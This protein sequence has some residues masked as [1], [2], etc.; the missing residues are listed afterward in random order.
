[1]D[2][3]GNISSILAASLSQPVP[4]PL[5]HDAGQFSAGFHCVNP[6][7]PDSDRDED[8]GTGLD[9]EHEPSVDRECDPTQCLFCN[10]VNS[11]VHSN[12]AHMRQAHGFVI[13]E[14][15]RLVVAIETLLAYFH[16]VIFGY[17]E[18]LYCG[19]QRR[20]AE[21]AQ[22]HMSGKGH[23]K[24]D[25]Y[26]EDSEFRDFYDFGS[27]LEGGDEV[28]DVSEDDQAVGEAVHDDDAKGAGPSG[29]RAEPKFVQPD[30]TT[31]RLASGKLL[32]HRQSVMTRPSH[33]KPRTG[34]EPTPHV[35]LDDVS[36]P[37]EPAPDSELDSTA[38]ALT[39]AQRREA[40]FTTRQLM[41]LRAEDRRSLLHLPMS[42]QRAILAVQK[43]Q[44]AKARRA[45]MAMQNRV[46]TLGNKTLMK[47]FVSD[48]PGRKNG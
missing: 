17:F 21:A 48:V 23:C 12:V 26:N 32:S 27:D 16:L 34:L 40:S 35:Q 24:F 20:T 39:R 19:S 31:L 28:G 33:R 25:L 22:H 42:Q 13:P 4:S 3:D 41:H 45:E 36:N 11:D 9:E 37:V 30:N 38:G 47:H 8:V 46:A 44:V 6:E 43:S 15:N 1:M 7:D 10:Q 2:S 18:C 5:S 14:I 29:K